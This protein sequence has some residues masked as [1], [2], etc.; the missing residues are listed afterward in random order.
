M[1]LV[2]VSRSEWQAA[3]SKT[4]QGNAKVQRIL[5][6]GDIKV[7]R[8]VCEASAR[9][10]WHKHSGTQLLIV[11]KGVC[12]LQKRGEVK[13]QAKKG[14]IVLIE[15]GEEHWHGASKDQAMVHLAVNINTR[16]DW[17]EPVSDA[18]YLA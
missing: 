16:T 4:F 12:W 13:R 9:M 1:K 5:G 15:A 3:D 11:T 6:G 2:N 8:V 14:D 7:F 18:E 17:L 10:N